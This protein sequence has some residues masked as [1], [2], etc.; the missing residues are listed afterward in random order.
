MSHLLAHPASLWFSPEAG[1]GALRARWKPHV[2]PGR[3]TL[4]L[5]EV[6]TPK[7]WVRI[8]RVTKA[9]TMVGADP[10]NY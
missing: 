9:S 7:T 4:L 10:E 6:V 8:Y 2:V 5:Q 1:C 3:Q